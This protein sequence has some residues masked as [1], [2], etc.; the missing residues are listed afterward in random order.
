MINAIKKSIKKFQV[1]IAMMVGGVT[2]ALSAYATPSGSEVND[3]LLIIG[4]VIICS[5][6]LGFMIVDYMHQRA[7]DRQQLIAPQTP[8]SVADRAAPAPVITPLPLKTDVELRLVT[9]DAKESD[10]LT[11]KKQPNV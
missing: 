11:S 2:M 9:E 1:P 8:H 5:S 6:F 4:G 7:E 3:V 10:P